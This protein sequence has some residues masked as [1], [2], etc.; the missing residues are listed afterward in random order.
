MQQWEKSPTWQ[1]CYV[2][3]MDL[4]VWIRSPCKS[5]DLLLTWRPPA[6]LISGSHNKNTPPTASGAVGGVRLNRVH[7]PVF[8]LV[9]VSLMRD[10][11]LERALGAFPVLWHGWARNIW[12]LSPLV[13][14]L[15]T[16]QQCECGQ[17]GVAG[18]AFID[19]PVA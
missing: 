7:T 10:S 17:P 14:P 4:R 19:Q 16:R 6:G 9:P 8:F 3:G 13:M 15:N 11:A 1:N 5:Q 12:S 2:R 18:A